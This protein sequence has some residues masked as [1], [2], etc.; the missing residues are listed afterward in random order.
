MADMAPCYIYLVVL[1]LCVDEGMGSTMRPGGST[2]QPGATATPALIC[3][4]PSNIP[5]T[6]WIKESF[7]NPR[8]NVT[9]C[10]R[11]CMK[12]WV[13]D[14]SGILNP[15]D[16]DFLDDQIDALATN[17]QCGCRN[18]VVGKDGYK[19]GVALVRKMGMKSFVVSNN[20]DKDNEAM[21]FS[22]YLRSVSWKFGTCDNSIVIFY[23]QEDRKMMT[24][25]GARA[26]HVL[27][28]NCT[29]EIF[30]EVKPMLKSGQVFEALHH[31][32]TRYG[33]V[34][35]T[36]QCH[37]PIEPQELGVGMVI[38]IVVICIVVGILAVIG[39]VCGWRRSHGS[40]HKGRSHDP[41]KGSDE[42][43]TFTGGETGDGGGVAGGSF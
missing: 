17:G 20:V 9:L 11:E 35:Q 21:E 43:K 23:S 38:L 33:Q 12:S 1:A 29:G 10:G 41:D 37:P 14:P 5:T 39:G 34:L 2:L 30:N 19:I 26:N 7:P 22:A 13:C 40:Y 16:A 36:G 25:T 28:V 6:D 31:M 3:T 42:P 15:K 18:C 24:S 27:T 4:I 8:V 32:V